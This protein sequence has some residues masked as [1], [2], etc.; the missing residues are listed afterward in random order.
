MPAYRLGSR[1]FATKGA[2]RAEVRRVL[3]K[4]QLGDLVVARD[5]DLIMALAANHPNKGG[6]WPGNITEL[7]VYRHGERGDQLYSHAR[8]FYAILDTG[9]QVPFS[10]KKCLDRVS[11]DETV[12]RACR[13]AV[14]AEIIAFK[15]EAMAGRSDID[16]NDVDHA[17][18][19]PFARIVDVFLA[20]YSGIDLRT[21]SGP[22]GLGVQFANDETAKHFAVFHHAK[23]QLQLVPRSENIKAGSRGYRNV[24]PINS[25]SDDI[26]ERHSKEMSD[27]QLLLFDPFLRPAWDGGYVAIR[28]D[29]LPDLVHSPLGKCRSCRFSG[30]LTADGRCAPCVIRDEK[31]RQRQRP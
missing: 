16:N 26:L 8:A 11:I 15:Q 13:R 22:G 27:E 18:D 30:P 28:L 10:Y 1:T 4:Y 23:A 19:W 3:H 7:R 14:A 9:E 20:E 25:P 29:L 6:A 31:A 2:A 17:G 24:I 21:M 5:H 12:T